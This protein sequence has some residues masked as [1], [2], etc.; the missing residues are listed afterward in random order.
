MKK[1]C[2]T[3]PTTRTNHTHHHTHL[4]SW[5]FT[6]G[7]PAEHLVVLGRGEEEVRVLW[8]PGNGEHSSLV[9]LQD[10]HWSSGKTKIPHLNKIDEYN[11]NIQCNIYISLGGSSF[12]ATLYI[13]P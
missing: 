2:R 9:V 13:I 10:P 1:L 11:Y 6:V 7:V 3:S 12:K 4:S 5:L 8:T